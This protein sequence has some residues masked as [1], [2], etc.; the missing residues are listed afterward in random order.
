ME[1]IPASSPGL[2]TH[3]RVRSGQAL[4]MKLVLLTARGPE[5]RWVAHH[6]ASAF[7][8]D[9]QAIVTSGPLARTWRSRLKSYVRRYSLAQLASRVV[10]RG[11]D[12]AVG[13]SRSR[14]RTVDSLLALPEAEDPFRP[15]LVKVVPGHNS[16]ECL[17]LLDRIAPDIVAVYGTGIIRTPVMARARIA[18]LNLHTGVSPRYRGADSSFWTIHN[19]EPEWAGAT[20]HALDTGV[21]SGAIFR[22]VRAGAVPGDDEAT[23]F[24][25]S[26]KA[27]A[28]AY[29]Q[30]IR[31][32]STGTAVA[33]PQRLEDGTEYRFVNRTLLSELRV[34]RRVAQSR[35]DLLPER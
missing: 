3:A 20:V 10:A 2:V 16:Q 25:K 17:D 13:W 22:T 32:V 33:T 18:A 29:V 1:V 23:L 7:P 35:R 11:V 6:I 19:G 30:V 21:D 8:D 26:V 27:G 4:S 24:S 5:H 34:L 31:D 28:D 9:L 15:E 14:Q 12:R